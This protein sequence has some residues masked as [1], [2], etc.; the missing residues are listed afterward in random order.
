MTHQAL[1]VAAITLLLP[2]AARLRAQTR[3]PAAPVE[4]IA[5]AFIALSVAELDRTVRWYSDVFG[6]RVEGSFAAD[7]NVQVR[8]L[9]ATGGLTVEL[10][11]DARIAPSPRRDRAEPATRGIFK[12]GFFVTNLDTAVARLRAHGVALVG[13]WPRSTPPNLLVKDSQGNLLQLFEHRR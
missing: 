9:R 7:S 5:P 12:V 8:I 1:L 13:H 11:R 4:V 6:M 2:A 10:L 3:A